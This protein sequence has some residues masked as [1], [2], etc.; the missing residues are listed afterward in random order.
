VKI[1]TLTL[2]NIDLRLISRKSRTA[3]PTR[4]PTAQFLLRADPVTYSEASLPCIGQAHACIIEPILPPSATRQRTTRSHG[5]CTTAA[6]GF[7]DCSKPERRQ[8]R[9]LVFGGDSAG[10]NDWV[11]LDPLHSSLVTSG[12]FTSVET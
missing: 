1:C 9:L 12:D 7:Y 4:R 11:T 8:L 6:A 10:S 3:L 5:I 2:L